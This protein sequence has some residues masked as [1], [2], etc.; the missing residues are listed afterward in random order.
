MQAKYLIPAIFSVALSACN[1]SGPATEAPAVPVPTLSELPAP[2]NEA[3]P[4]NGA[5]VF[6]KCRSCH[7]V[8]AREGNK[9]GPNLHGVFDRP[10]ATA[11]KFNYSAVL[12]D[13]DAERWTPELVDQ[14]LRQPKK[15]LPGN[16]MFFDG[17]AEE[18]DRRDLIAWLLIETRK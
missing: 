1:G 3:D 7:T 10:P 11:R 13:F 12:K 16:A 17:I 9:V 6:A 2:W 15:F 4:G 5:T 18:K 14:W 8:V